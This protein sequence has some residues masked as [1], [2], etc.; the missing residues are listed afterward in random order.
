MQRF[1]E[2][3]LFHAECISLSMLTVSMGYYICH[4]IEII[5]PSQ[6]LSLMGGIWMSAVTV[7]LFPLMFCALAILGVPIDIMGVL[8]R[9]LVNDYSRC[10]HVI[11]VCGNVDSYFN[12]NKWEQVRTT[13]WNETNHSDYIEIGHVVYHRGLRCTDYV[14]RT[15]IAVSMV[16]YTLTRLLRFRLWYATIRPLP[17][18]APTN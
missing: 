4:F 16:I 6:Q 15:L 3:A 13:P 10:E 5:W 7:I 12:Y 2:S 1:Y 18:C 14:I 17:A 11:D 9:I 8:F